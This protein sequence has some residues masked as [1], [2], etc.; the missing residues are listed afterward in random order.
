M[1]A[2]RLHR[3]GVW[4]RRDGIAAASL[5][6]RTVACTRAERRTRKIG[7]AGKRGKKA[8]GAHRYSQESA[9]RHPRS[10]IGW[11]SHFDGDTMAYRRGNGRGEASSAPK[12]QSRAS[13]TSPCVG[14]CAHIERYQ[15]ERKCSTLLKQRSTLCGAA[16]VVQARA[17]HQRRVYQHLRQRVQRV[18]HTLVR[19][20]LYEA[21]LRGMALHRS[22][23][24]AQKKMKTQ[25]SEDGEVM[26]QRKGEGGSQ[27]CPV[28][29]AGRAR[30]STEEGWP[31]GESG[32]VVGE[33]GDGDVH[34]GEG[35]SS[36]RTTKRHGKGYTWALR[37][38]RPHCT[39]RV[40]PRQRRDRTASV[41]QY[42]RP[43]IVLFFFSRTS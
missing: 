27:R 19:T 32:G 40:G 26:V 43:C 10:R 3:G 31:R 5:S 13:I 2:A 24:D 15:P 16:H 20:H 11:H 34:T 37:H 39:R 8:D 14:P 36:A 38:I 23:G 28:Q 1:Q 4:C 17:P 42:C 35:G 33:E 7:E 12:M 18:Q 9:H 6:R 21:T 29:R 41:S 25:Q 22:R 30:R